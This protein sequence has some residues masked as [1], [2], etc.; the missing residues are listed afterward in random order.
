VVTSAAAVMVAVFSIFA[1]MSLLPMKQVGVGLATAVFLDATVVRGVL[2][3]AV[4]TGL[5]HRAHSGP[6][7]LRARHG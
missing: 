3:P 6:R 5:G 1:M 7:W 4:L 2:L